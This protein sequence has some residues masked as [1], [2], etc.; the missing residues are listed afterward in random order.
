MES[1]KQKTKQ[2]KSNDGSTLIIWSAPADILELQEL[3]NNYFKY[4]P[5]M[6]DGRYRPPYGYKI[7]DSSIFFNNIK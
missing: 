2:N 3:V 5:I 4:Y 7:K 6:H 1:K